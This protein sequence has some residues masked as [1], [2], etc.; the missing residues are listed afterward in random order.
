MSE[1]DAGI[2]SEAGRRDD[3]KILN[4]DH[5]D[6]GR[7]QDDS[8]DVNPAHGGCFFETGRVDGEL[9]AL[10]LTRVASRRGHHDTNDEDARDHCR[11][12][13]AERD[14]PDDHIDDAKCGDPIPF[15][16]Q[17]SEFRCVSKGLPG[18]SPVGDGLGL[19]DF[20]WAAVHAQNADED[21]SARRRCDAPF[22]AT[23]PNAG[24]RSYIAPKHQTREM[25]YCM[26]SRLQD[27]DGVD[28]MDHERS[29]AIETGSNRFHAD[30]SGRRIP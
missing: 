17:S 20:P 26:Y 28:E 6:L 1:R 22:L 23:C 3:I 21:D 16:A 13:A 29:L 30:G 14:Q 7:E 4:V 12:G 24:I 11:S 8:G 18:L 25:S 19:D 10:P 2:G 5:N 27:T 9:G 15:G